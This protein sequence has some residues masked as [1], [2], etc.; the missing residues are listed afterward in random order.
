MEIL[1]F[2]IAKKIFEGH[3]ANHSKPIAGEYPDIF[4]FLDLI[5]DH[6][7]LSEQIDTTIV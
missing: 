3:L 2:L 4:D 7:L 1:R 6:G 5:E